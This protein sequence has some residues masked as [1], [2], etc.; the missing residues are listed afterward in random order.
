[1]E[2]I[3]GIF[4]ES[5]WYVA[6]ILVTMTTLIAGLINQAFKITKGIW[7]QVVAWV[8]GIGLSVSAW[9]IKLI[10][11]GDPVWLGVVCLS[12]VTGLASNGV[13]DIPTIKS[14]IDSW[15]VKKSN[16]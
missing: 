15:F 7:P 5:F 10:T 16:S 12:I 3:N 13:Y 6:P 8:V 1:M 9:A 14:W 11:F 2:Q 4:S